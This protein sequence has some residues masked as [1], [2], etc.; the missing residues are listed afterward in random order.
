MALK[1]ADGKLQVSQKKGNGVPHATYLHYNGVVGYE[2]C[3]Y[4]A[5]K[6]SLSIPDMLTMAV[7]HL[8]EQ[9]NLDIYSQ[10][11]NVK[12]GRIVA[13]LAQDAPPTD[14]PPQA[15]A[16]DV[17]PTDAPPQAQDV[18]PTDAPQA[19]AKKHNR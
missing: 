15:Q 7:L 3:K 12:L 19:Q 14:A 9:A 4:L 16:Q 10:Y 8:K 17:P 1:L 2:D 11:V 5:D 6:V 13:P 18:P